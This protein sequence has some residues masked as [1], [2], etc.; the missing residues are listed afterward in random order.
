MSVIPADWDAEISPDKNISKT[1]ISTN[2]P[3]IGSMSIIATTQE[4]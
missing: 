3:G 1:P 2:K 4:A